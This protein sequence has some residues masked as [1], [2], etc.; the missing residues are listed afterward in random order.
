MDKRAADRISEILNPTEEQRARMLQNILEERHQKRYQKRGDASVKKLKPAVAMLVACLLL[1]TAAV[2]MAY[3]GLDAK[4]ISFLKPSGSEQET[5]LASGACQVDRQMAGENGTLTV[6]QAIGDGNLVYLLMEFTAPDG[7]VLDGARYRFDSFD[8]D[9]GQSF[10]STDFLSVEDGNPN[11][12]QISLVMSIMTK[13]SLAGQTVHLKLSDLQAA[14]P[15]PGAFQTVAAGDWE[16][17]FELGF[18]EYSTLYSVGQP[19]K[20]FDCDATIKSVSVSPISITMKVESDQLKEINQAAGGGMQSGQINLDNFPITI[21]YQDGTSET[22]TE[23]KGMYLS[24]YL[25]GEMLMI[26]T[27]DSVINDKEIQSISFFDTKIPINH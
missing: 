21:H 16:T 23:F 8:F 10:S 3:M 26:K 1:A 18:Q 22:T 20:L 24:E 27:F 5:D 14:E 6:K 12:N 2:A 9:A 4:F 25:S 17:S 13:D 15:F 7:V 19:I 11:D